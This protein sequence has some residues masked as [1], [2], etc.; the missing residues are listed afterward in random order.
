MFMFVT[1][2]A[3]GCDV[4]ATEDELSI[5]S[6]SFPSSPSSEPAEI[7]D[8]K[9]PSGGDCESSLRLSITPGVCN[10]S[11]CTYTKRINGEPIMPVVVK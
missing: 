6:S 2:K 9:L 7:Y 11:S 8:D 4:F 10:P 1:S 5:S 3:C